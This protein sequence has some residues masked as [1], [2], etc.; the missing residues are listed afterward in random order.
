MYQKYWMNK[1]CGDDPSRNVEYSLV[2]TG[3]SIVLCTKYF[4]Y[5]PI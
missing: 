4:H 5:N 1:N 2:P 3:L